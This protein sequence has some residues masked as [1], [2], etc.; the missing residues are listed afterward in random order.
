[1]PVAAQFEREEA[2]LAVQQ[3]TDP[4]GTGAGRTGVGQKEHALDARPCPQGQLG[5]GAVFFDA[6]L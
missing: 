2:R 3:I 1:V 4:L 5:L 6:E